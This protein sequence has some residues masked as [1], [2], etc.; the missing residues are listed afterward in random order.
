MKLGVGGMPVKE[1]TD[2]DDFADIAKRIDLYQQIRQRQMLVI[3]DTEINL[4]NV[5]GS[6]R[7][8]EYFSDVVR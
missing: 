6:D 5:N 7:F 4:T 2:E 1:L 3:S 8:F